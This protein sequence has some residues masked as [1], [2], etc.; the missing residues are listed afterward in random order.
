MYLYAFVLSPSTPPLFWVTFLAPENRE[1]WIH[2]SPVVYTHSSLQ[3]EL[4]VMAKNSLLKV[5]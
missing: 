4:I 1:M 5:A 2:I 3:G